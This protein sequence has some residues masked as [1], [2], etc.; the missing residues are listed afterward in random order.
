ML[1]CVGWFC[2]QFRQAREPPLLSR[3]GWPADS[4]RSA[5][6]DFFGVRTLSTSMEITTSLTSARNTPAAHGDL[7]QRLYAEFSQATFRQGLELGCRRQLADAG[8]IAAARGALG[9][10]T[11]N[12]PGQRSRRFLRHGRPPGSQGKPGLFACRSTILNTLSK[13]LGAAPR[14]LLR[15]GQDF[16][17]IVL[18]SGHQPQDR[19]LPAGSCLR[20]LAYS[21]L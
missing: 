12:R 9:R 8:Q 21:A 2:P 4:W 13:P 1:A 6:E 17:Q 15:V 19:D 20:A 14:G 3:P 10:D 5:P 7:R 16:R 18:G 11:G